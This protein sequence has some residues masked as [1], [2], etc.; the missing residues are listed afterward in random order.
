MSLRAA[1]GRLD[2]GAWLYG[3]FSAVIGGGAGAATAGVGA[4]LVVPG[5]K[6]WQ[7]LSIMAMTFLVSGIFAGLAYLHQQPLPAVTTT[8]KTTSTVTADPGGGVTAS[9]SVETVTVQKP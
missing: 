7:T 4:N 5:L 9:K 3:L 1:I 8:E 6:A 2:W